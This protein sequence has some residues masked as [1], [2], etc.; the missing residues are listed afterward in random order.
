MWVRRIKPES[1][2]G[3]FNQVC[4]YGMLNPI[5]GLNTCNILYLYNLRIHPFTESNC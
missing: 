1:V 4:G 3:E 5:K 2:Y